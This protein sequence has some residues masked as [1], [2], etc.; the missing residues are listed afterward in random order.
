MKNGRTAVLILSEDDADLERLPTSN[1]TLQELPSERRKI[2]RSH[3]KNVLW[4]M[5]RGGVKHP[6]SSSE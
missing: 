1:Q 6:L 4:M 5:A 2:K 3:S